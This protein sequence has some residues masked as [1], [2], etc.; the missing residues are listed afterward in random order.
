[1]RVSIYLDSHYNLR[2]FCFICRYISH[3]I[4][5]EYYHDFISVC[6]NHTKVT[7]SLV[8]EVAEKAAN[9]AHK[10]YSFT[11]KEL[12]IEKLR[13]F[14]FVR[15]SAYKKSLNIPNSLQEEIANYSTP[16]PSIE[17]SLM[18]LPILL[19]HHISCFVKLE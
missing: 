14:P 15:V 17:G 18:Q 7:Y 6:P 2:C 3:N 13:D 16:P 10:S 4:P 8:T 5:N 11:L 19:R 1:M 9:I 12:A